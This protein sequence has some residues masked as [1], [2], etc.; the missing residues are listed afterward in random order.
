MSLEKKVYLLESGNSTKNFSVSFLYLSH[1][2]ED[3][4]IYFFIIKKK[5]CFY[6]EVSSFKYF[7]VFSHIASCYIFLFLNNNSYTFKFNYYIFL[8]IK[9]NFDVNMCN[10]FWIS[11]YHYAFVKLWMVYSFSSM[12]FNQMSTLGL[13]FGLKLVANH[14]FIPFNP[15]IIGSKPPWKQKTWGNY[16]VHAVTS[17][18]LSFTR[19]FMLLSWD[20]IPV[21][22]R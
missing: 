7:N 1:A 2:A 11:L 10:Q 20:F 4:L 13:C 17:D 15:S 9:W 16:P 6:P 14:S 19:N 21:Y 18:E 22:H 8:N 12:S 5:S 3:P